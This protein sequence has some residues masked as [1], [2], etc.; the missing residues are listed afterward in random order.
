MGSE[1]CI[2]DRFGGMKSSGYGREGGTEG[3]H[4]YL[5]VKN[6]SQSIPIV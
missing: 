6:V 3:L 4:H 5:T 1:M 2:R